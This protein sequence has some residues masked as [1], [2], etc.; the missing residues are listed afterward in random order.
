M[1]KLYIF[2]KKSGE[3]EMEKEMGEIPDE[4]RREDTVILLKSL[5]VHEGDVFVLTYT[6]EPDDG[7]VFSWLGDEYSANDVEVGEAESLG[8]AIKMAVQDFFRIIRELEE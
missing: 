8:E 1:C 4:M 6:W 5:V 2:V 7:R 3:I